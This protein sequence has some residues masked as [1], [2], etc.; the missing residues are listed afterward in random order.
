MMPQEMGFA[1]HRELASTVCG[2]MASLSEAIINLDPLSKCG[3]VVQDASL[4]LEKEKSGFTSIQTAFRKRF[5]G[6]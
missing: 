3:W 6:T 1:V 2:M 4:V 5:P